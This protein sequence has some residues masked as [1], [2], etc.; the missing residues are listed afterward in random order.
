MKE[1]RGSEGE[2][3]GSG[4]WQEETMLFGER[5]RKKGKKELPPEALRH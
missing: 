4:K 5:E 3:I 1:K 2:E